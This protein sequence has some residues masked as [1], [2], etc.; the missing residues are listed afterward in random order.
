MRVYQRNKRWWVDFSYNGRRYRKAAGRTK[1]EALLK[2]GKIVE[3]LKEEA[4]GTPVIAPRS[5][6]QYAEEYLEYSKAEKAPSTYKRE[7]CKMG[8][9]CRIF[10]DRRLRDIRTVDIEHYKQAR[11]SKAAPATVNRE[12]ALI[13]HMF[14]KAVDWNYADHNPAQR[15]KLF[16]EPSGRIRYLSLEERRLLLDEC[17][18]ILKAVVMTA[19]ETGMRKGEL[20][21]LP[22]RNVDFERRTIK[23]EHTKNNEARILPMSN[24]LKPALETLYLQRTGALVFSKDDGKPYGNWR[25]AFEKAAK[26]AG[27]A[28]FRFHDLRHTFA[29]YMIMYGKVDIHTLQILMGHK[30]IQMTMRYSHL[31]QAHLLEAVNRLGTNLA[32]IEAEAEGNLVSDEF[33]NAPVA[34]L[35]RA[36][37]F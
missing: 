32:Q 28:D 19:L 29:S 13:K 8:F 2:L 23:V 18:G 7:L 33:T 9:L 6:S 15:V 17:E 24:T 31:S 14:T 37:D 11:I 26:R 25:K 3:R 36:S 30:T 34:Q 21:T 12:I 1:R 22:W 35:D 5:F 10:G 16:K 4:N 20:Q 27:I